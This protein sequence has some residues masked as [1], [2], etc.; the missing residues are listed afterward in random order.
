MDALQK[1]QE[2]EAAEAAKNDAMNGAFF[3]DDFSLDLLSPRLRRPMPMVRLSTLAFRQKPPPWVML[4]LR[5]VLR[6]LP[7]S[8]YEA[9]QIES[10]SSWNQLADVRGNVYE[11]R[12]MYPAFLAEAKASWSHPPRCPRPPRHP[13]P[14]P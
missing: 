7:W 2:A 12:M 8:S 1:K 10:L 5:F 14:E 3:G 6:V 9:E 11:A 13:E 4:L